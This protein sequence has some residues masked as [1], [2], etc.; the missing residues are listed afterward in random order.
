MESLRGIIRMTLSVCV[1]FVAYFISVYLLLGFIG[2]W[3]LLV[4]LIVPLLIIKAFQSKNERVRLPQEV[5]AS[6]RSPLVSV[7]IFLLA[8]GLAFVASIAV[9]D[10]IACGGH[11]CDPFRT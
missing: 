11:F 9:L 2:F 5:I 3:A 8:V 1:A 10:L 7:L 4:A 6:K